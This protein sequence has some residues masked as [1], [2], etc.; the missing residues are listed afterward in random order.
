[1]I[2]RR[3]VAA[4]IGGHHLLAH[5]HL[6]LYQGGQASKALLIEFGQQRADGLTVFIGLGRGAAI[7]GEGGIGEELLDLGGVITQALHRDSSIMECYLFSHGLIKTGE[8]IEPVE[9]NGKD[10]Q[11]Y[12]T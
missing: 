3:L 2:A 5:T 7:G 8:H 1:M 11:Q 4:P 12:Q 9:I 10:H 6:L